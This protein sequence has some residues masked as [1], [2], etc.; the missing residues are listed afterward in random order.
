MWTRC[1]PRGLGSVAASFLF[2]I[3][4][5]V[6]VS[7]KIYLWLMAARE[8]VERLKT[9]GTAVRKSFDLFHS[10]TLKLGIGALPWWFLHVLQPGEDLGGVPSPATGT[11]QRA[12]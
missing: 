2:H 1:G 9:V 12:A 11:H 5:W 10:V 8:L 4:P 6:T 7:R 3:V